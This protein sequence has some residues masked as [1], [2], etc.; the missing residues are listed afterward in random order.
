MN[1]AVHFIAEID[2][3]ADCANFK[4]GTCAFRLNSPDYVTASVKRDDRACSN[5][6]V[7]STRIDEDYEVEPVFDGLPSQVFLE[8]DMSKSHD[9]RRVLELKVLSVDALHR[10]GYENEQ[11]PVL[12]VSVSHLGETAIFFL[13]NT[14]HRTLK[15]GSHVARVA[16]NRYA[17]DAMFARVAEK[18]SIKLSNWQRVQYEL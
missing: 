18:G 15:H 10:L 16:C 2:T 13:P 11:Y 1:N 8:R 12:C 3:C 6:N 4:S 14:V 9:N 17:I 5:F 7:P